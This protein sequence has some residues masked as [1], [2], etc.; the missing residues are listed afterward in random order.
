MMV[1]LDGAE[2]NGRDQRTRIW[3]TLATYSLPRCRTKPLRVSRIDWRPCLV[4]NLGCPTRRP[5]RVPD[6]EANQLR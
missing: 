4:R 5:L 6:R 1:T 3:P 2:G